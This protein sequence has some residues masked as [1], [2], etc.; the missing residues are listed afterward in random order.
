MP[1]VGEAVAAIGAESREN[2][3]IVLVRFEGG[4]PEHFVLDAH[5]AI[6]PLQPSTYIATGRFVAGSVRGAGREAANLSSI[7][8][9]AI[10]SDLKDRIGYKPYK[11]P[12]AEVDELQAEHLAEI[13]RVCRATGLQP[14]YIANTGYGFSLWYAVDPA[15]QG[16][17]ADWRALLK[18]MVPALN[19]FAGWQFADR[20][21]SDAG[22]RIMRIPGATNT[23]GAAPRPSFIVHEDGDCWRYATLDAYVSKI[24]VPPVPLVIA[25]AQTFAPADLPS[26]V[27]G[28]IAALVRPHWTDGQRHDLALG[29]AGW[30]RR[31]G[32]SEQQAASIIAD[33]STA[34]GDARDHQRAVTSTYQSGSSLTAGYTKVRE[35]LP[36]STV[37]RIDDLLSAFWRAQK[38]AAAPP[39]TIIVMSGNAPQP[40]ETPADSGEDG[41]EERLTIEYEPLPDVVYQGATAEYIDIMAPCT[42]APEQF[43]LGGFLAMNGALA[44]RVAYTPY[45]S[46]TVY[47]NQYVILVG[48]T[49]TSKKDTA[50]RF[51]TEKFGEL[52]TVF[53]SG[54]MRTAPRWSKLDDAGSDVALLKFL[55]DN[56]NTLL[57]VPEL[58]ALIAKMRSKGREALFDI[59]LTLWDANPRYQNVTLATPLE[60]HNPT[61]SWL[62]AIQPARLRAAMSEQILSSGFMNRPLIIPGDALGPLHDPPSVNVSASRALLEEIVSRYDDMATLAAGS[63]PLALPMSPDCKDAWRAYYERNWYQSKR[64]PEAGETNSRHP[65]LVRK[66]ALHYALTDLSTRSLPSALEWRHMEAAIAVLDWKAKHVDLLMSE[67]GGTDETRIEARILAALERHGALS[68]RRLKQLTYIKGVPTS[69]WN[70]ALT[71]L[72][73]SGDVRETAVART[74]VLG[75]FAEQQ[76]KG[77]T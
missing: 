77:A 64:N 68:A 37:Q 9:I 17:V 33:C 52:E 61:L 7:W 66:V 55:R 51:A 36:V 23:K 42:E 14:N 73:K 18:R 76:M 44:G 74:Y 16:R 34:G 5:N 21:A 29:L 40:E 3:D 72:E 49:G 22:T 45:A 30:L 59:M 50:I 39:E 67:W 35:I 47:A 27:A 57:V 15:E 41:G 2:E 6:A 31:N 20:Q 28:E 63:G 43:H 38:R 75:K 12:S 65:D 48:P 25:P 62:A 58:S 54:I 71:S 11:L 53:S 26:E 1:T 46:K 60:V 10:D 56:P 8:T 69:I 24:D 13:V 70:R 19:A 4:N 32:V